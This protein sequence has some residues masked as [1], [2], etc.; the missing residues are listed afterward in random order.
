M[1]MRVDPH[2]APPRT[3]LAW[4]MA[5]SVHSTCKPNRIL[6]GSRNWD[7]GIGPPPPQ[8]MHQRPWVTL[9]QATTPIVNKRADTNKHLSDCCLPGSRKSEGSGGEYKLLDY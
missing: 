8:Y 9:N 4:Q 7:H 1:T 3:S 5:L 2:G 6:L